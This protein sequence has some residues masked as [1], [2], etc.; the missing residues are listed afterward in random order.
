MKKA[1]IVLIVIAA[2]I[3][4][5]LA[6]IYSGIFNV[7]AANPDSGIKAWLLSTVTDNSVE[8]HAKGIVAPPLTDSSLINTGLSHYRE[9]CVFC[10][11]APGTEP[12][13]IGRGLNPE[14]PNLSEVAGEW[15]DAELFWILKNGIKMTGMPSF[16][17]TYSDHQIWAMVSFVRTLP[18]MTADRYD[19]LNQPHSDDDTEEDEEPDEDH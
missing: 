15:S 13:G 6:F 1:I 11:G 5:G 3:A 9:I 18:G 7:S 4:V 16:G 17:A 19:S 8:R 10:H 2:M 14:A 12:S